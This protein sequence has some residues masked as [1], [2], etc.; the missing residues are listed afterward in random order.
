MR[1]AFIA[2]LAATMILAAA[3]ARAELV[4]M[5]IALTS[6]NEVPAVKSPASASADVTLD[7]ATR[8]LSW[9]MKFSGLTTA[10]TAAHFHGPAAPT[11]NGGIIVPINIG[12]A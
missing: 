5:P 3:T 8:V 7:T 9:A 1:P 4:R 11:A 6:S 2:T 10:A 12:N